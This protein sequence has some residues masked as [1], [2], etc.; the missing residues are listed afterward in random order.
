MAG[1]KKFGTFAGVYTP[2]VLTIL[3]VIMYMRLGWVIGQ[4][5]LI[6]AIAIILIAHII[7][8][9]TSL[10]ISSIATDKKIK[11]GGIYY[12]LSRSLGLPM[13]GSIGI[14]LFVGTA[15]SIALYIVGFTENFLGIEA[16][17]NFLGMANDINS[18]RIIGSIVLLSLVAIA[19]ISTSLAIKSQ[20]FVLGA[21]ALSLISIGLGFVFIDPATISAPIMTPSDTGIPLITVFAIFFP[22][23]TGF[24]AGVA[25]SGD[26]KDPKSSIPKGTMYAVA[27]GL[28]VYVVLSI[29]IA[30]FVDRDTLL[31]DNNFFLKIALYSPLVIAGIW[32]ATLSSALGGILGA[33]RIIQAISNDKI[34]PSFLGKGHGESNEPRNALIF[35]FVIAEIGVLI[36][37]LDA[38][39]E[40]VSMFY[41]AAYGFI[42]LAFALESWAS[43][44]FRPTFAVNKWV[45][46]LGFIASFGVMMQLNPG[47]MFAAFVIMWII[48]FLLKRKEIK[49]DFGDVWGSVWSSLVRTSITKLSEKSLEK[50]N[51]KPNILLF[52]GDSSQRTHLFNI[53]SKFIG[54]YGFLSVFD[55]VIDKTED[56]NFSFTKEEQQVFSE[57]HSDGIFVRQHS[58]DNV[59]DGIEQISSTYGFAGVEPNTIFMGWARN[60]TNPKRFTHMLNRLYSLDQN[61]VMMDY[62]Q[63]L[64]FGDKKQIDVWWRGKGQNGNLSL[65]LIK[66]LQENDEWAKAKLRLMVVNPINDHYEELYRQ[67]NQI[68]NF[69]RIDGEVRI[70]NNQIENRSFYDII[71]VESVNSSLIFLGLAD[72]KKGDEEKFINNTNDLCQSIGTVVLVKAS[73]Q[74][75][76]L[77]IGKIKNKI[78]EAEAG[79]YQTT[80][81]QEELAYPKYKNLKNANINFFEKLQGNLDSIKENSLH[82]SIDLENNNV[83]ELGNLING[84][85]TD[86]KNIFTDIKEEQ[87]A[88]KISAVHTKTFTELNKLL[89]NIKAE[90]YKEENKVSSKFIKEEINSL[91]STYNS[92]PKHIKVKYSLADM[93]KNFADNIDT[94]FYKWTNRKL[95]LLGKKEFIYTIKYKQLLTEKLLDKHI[96]LINEMLQRYGSISSENITDIEVFITKLDKELHNLFHQARNS[97]I[98]KENNP[99]LVNI[100]NHINNLVNNVNNRMLE[101]IS[102][103]ESISYCITQQ[104]N[105]LSTTI[106]VNS[107]LDEEFNIDKSIAKAGNYF[108]HIPEKRQHNQEI[109]V[110][111]V[112]LNLTLLV[113]AAQLRHFTSLI[114]RRVDAN[115]HKDVT[116]NQQAYLTYLK[117]F[118]TRYLKNEDTSF[119]FSYDKLEVS[120]DQNSAKSLINMLN[121]TQKSILK[122]LPDTIEIFSEESDNV[123]GTDKQYGDLDTV[124]ISVIRLIDF[125]IQDEFTNKIE[126]VISDLPEQI[127]QQSH[128]LQDHL[129]FL[130]YSIENKN[131]IGKEFHTFIDDEI[132]TIEKNKALS[133]EFVSNTLT[134]IEERQRVI[135]EKI[136]LYPFV[137]AAMN[138]KQYIKQRESIKSK[139]RLHILQTKLN[140]WFNNLAASIWYQESESIILTQNILNEEDSDYKIKT[141]L[142]KSIA[143]LKGSPEVINNL[144]YYYQQ[145]FTNRQNYISEFW[146]N[147][148]EAEQELNNFTNDKKDNIA[149]ALLIK[150]L[151][152]SGKSHLSYRYISSLSDN[153]NIITITP[154]VGGSIDIKVFENTL[155]NAIDEKNIHDLSKL[156]EGSVII[157]E[158][159]ELWWQKSAEGFV[160]FDR[161]FDIINQYSEKHT[162]VVVINS[163]T[164]SIIEKLR[165]TKRIFSHIININVMDARS[166]QSMIWN[167]HQSGGLKLTY[168]NKSEDSFHPWDFAR[169]FSK[170]Y[171]SSKGHINSAMYNWI[172]NIISINEKEIKIRK[173]IILNSNTLDILSQNEIWIIYSLLI[174]KQLSINALTKITSFDIDFTN[175]KMIELQRIGIIEQKAK[176]IYEISPLLM[177]YVLQLLKAKKYI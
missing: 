93:K 87:F 1:A 29:A 114:L 97:K 71:N 83:R 119:N 20:F 82:K 28:V 30:Y 75:M 63:K 132:T 39:A 107:L 164:Y 170:Y 70:I 11:T 64:E 152:G 167:R 175:R 66:F 122:S 2:S 149:K 123:I 101:F 13:G 143:K 80:K 9:T 52:S 67:A 57:E 172:N 43:T 171:K 74:F 162:I 42:N 159:L 23:V 142:R 40:V 8:I 111:R 5:G 108:D 10:S 37:E 54:K 50:R 176:N 110:N 56:N 15:L 38:I 156:K 105:E 102:Y 18:I 65:Q 177:P 60:T 22:A 148:P 144:P 51:W 68:L 34:I 24:T 19:F 33:P 98:I 76:N 116:D 55:L 173:P 31:T 86:I 109:L 95:A 150:G 27:T 3:G 146:I 99:E 118:R 153:S 6:A 21:I 151:P 79:K 135:T 100:E 168:A 117:A 104:L 94:K 112:Q 17:S 16:I 91:K 36:G 138:L 163:Y 46:I 154:P 84:S 41:I 47:A 103:R 160:V 174:H 61:V 161:I 72:I 157:F 58:V 14:T 88:T 44:D 120:F 166:I 145:L 126:Q 130:S 26:L 139:N 4:A 45:G 129:R 81:S 140:Y 141:K 62:D 89:V 113:F 49:S 136:S 169:L 96:L 125:I 12:I 48:Y 131:S 134:Q 59:Y 158:D 92:S 165:D 7:S 90:T 73:S 147:M 85:I 155:Q 32:G 53:G 25:M 115:L 69:L 35:T 127:T 106:G 128:Y 77:K 121:K 78:Q 137:Q 124:K 133:E